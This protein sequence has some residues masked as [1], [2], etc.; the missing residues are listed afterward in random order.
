[1]SNIKIDFNGYI[2]FR[3][4]EILKL[5]ED[6]G[7]K[8]FKYSCHSLLEFMKHVPVIKYLKI[9]LCSQKLILIIRT[10]YS[11]ES[12]YSTMK[13]IKCKHRSTLTDDHLTELLKT[14]LTT[15]SPNFK[16]LTS[17]INTQQIRK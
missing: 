13:M 2:S 4:I 16:K 3:K 7:L 1:M 10:T 15:Y 5:L 11:C 9:T 17:K 12:L 8:P 6:K 14:A